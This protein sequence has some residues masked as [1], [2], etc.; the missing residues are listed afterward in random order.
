M[1]AILNGCFTAM[2]VKFRGLAEG[3]TYSFKNHG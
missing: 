3:G 1:A 2:Q